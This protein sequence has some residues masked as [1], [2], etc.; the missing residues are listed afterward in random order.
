MNKTGLQ[1]FLAPHS[2]G[3]ANSIDTDKRTSR[4]LTLRVLQMGFDSGD[5][6]A[7]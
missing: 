7:A 2:K 3:H 4:H 1:T 6:H 5:D